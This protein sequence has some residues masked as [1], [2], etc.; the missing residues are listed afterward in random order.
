MFEMMAMARP[1]I[2]SL[3]GEAAEILR[4]SGAAG[5]RTGKQS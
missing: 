5:G 3:R 4:R 1:I 2:G